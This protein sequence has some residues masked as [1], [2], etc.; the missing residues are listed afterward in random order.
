M[1]KARLIITAVIIEKRTVRD[2]VN[3]Y[4]VSRSWVYELLARYREHGDEAF[5]P[6]SKR[7]HTSPTKIP[8]HTIELIIKLRDEL[9]TKGL[10][11]GPTTIAWHLTHHHNLTVSPATIHRHL[12]TAGRITAQPKKKPRTA[13][14]RFEAEQPNETWQSDITHYPLADGTDTEIITWLDDHSRYALSITAHRPVNGTTVINTFTHT[15]ETYGYPA[16]TLTD[17]GLVYTTRFAGGRN[18]NSRNGFETLLTKLGIKQ[19]N[20]RPNHPTTCGKVERFQQTLK[21]WLHAQPH[22]PRTLTELN[23]TLETFRHTY[24]HHR[25]HRSLN[26]TTPNTAYHTRPKATPT[27]HTNTHWRVRHD[28]ID[29]T[30]K[31]TLRYNGHMYKIGIGRKWARTH[32][33]CLIKDLN[34]RIINTHTGETLRTLTLDTTRTYQPQQRTNTPRK[35]QHPDP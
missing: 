24:N 3:E 4:S 31:I 34:I 8:D 7:P 22:Q 10:D 15:T 11:A 20:S 13:Y 35:P 29:T 2:V 19:K 5:E 6:R 30:G 33:I 21:N 16:S 18:N 14:T 23:T 25:P 27:G 9:T 17:N 32:I 26:N 28:R 12:K 1:S